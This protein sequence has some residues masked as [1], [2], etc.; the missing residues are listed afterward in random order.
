MA[1]DTKRPAGDTGVAEIYTADKGLPPSDPDMG[2]APPYTPP[3]KPVKKMAQGG[4][5]SSR[6]DGIAVRG[7]TK[8]RML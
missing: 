2:S 8:G 1:K 5:A 4:S 7:K 3:K 6:A